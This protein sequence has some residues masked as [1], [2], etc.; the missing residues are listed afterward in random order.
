MG[1]KPRKKVPLRKLAP[2]PK[3]ITLDAEVL[4]IDSAKA[5]V[6]NALIAARKN[7]GEIVQG[8]CSH[9]DSKAKRKSCCVLC[10]IKEYR[11][12]KASDDEATVAKAL[13]VPERFL[14]DLI[15]GFDNDKDEI[16]FSQAKRLGKALW[17]KYGGPAA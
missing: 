9:C 14:L 13:G 15:S 11:G 2:L 7:H 3:K 1:M 4:L 12:F 6:S 5:L 10:A 8:W 17:R 16:E